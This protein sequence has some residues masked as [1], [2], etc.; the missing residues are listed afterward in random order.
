MGKLGEIILLIVLIVVVGA[1]AVAFSYGITN[2]YSD[3]LENKDDLVQINALV[4]NMREFEDSEDDTYYKIYLTYEYDG[5]LYENIYWEDTYKDDFS[6]GKEIEVEISSVNPKYIRK[7]DIGKR[8]LIIILISIS[9]VLAAV[10]YSAGFYKIKSTD[11]LRII[12]ENAIARE[13]S[14]CAVYAFINGVIGFGVSM[15]GASLFLP[16][17]VT[18]R[19]NAILIVVVG[20]AL[21]CWTILRTK[22]SGV[23][24]YTITTNLCTKKWSESDGDSSSDYVRFENIPGNIRT[25]RKVYSHSEEGKYYYVL[26]NTK[27]EI[28][29]VYDVKKWVLKVDNDNW[30]KAGKKVVLNAFANALLISVVV[31]FIPLILKLTSLSLAGKL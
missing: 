28:R 16:E 14:P 13:L 6:I 8:Y 18:N 1:F 2:P 19:K 9:G 25:G 11:D 4:S 21:L 29:E 7:T 24:E 3:Y 12:D 5:E 15:Y 10:I 17:I 30:D 20:F 23:G 31:F 26:S 27:G 22:K